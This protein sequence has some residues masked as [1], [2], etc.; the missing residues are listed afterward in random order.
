MYALEARRKM[1]E[2][3]AQR[4]Q[5]KCVRR[6]VSHWMPSHST[7]LHAMDGARH[8]FHPRQL[9]ESRGATHPER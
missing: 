4:L 9:S 8:L 1:M 5:N 2:R 6:I 3:M 7:T